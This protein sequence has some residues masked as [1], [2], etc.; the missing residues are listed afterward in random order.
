MKHASI[1]TGAALLMAVALTPAVAGETRLGTEEIFNALA[2]KTAIYAESDHV[3]YFSPAGLTPYWDGERHTEGTWSVDSNQYCSVWPP[4]PSRDCYDIYRTD[5][6]EI[7][8]VGESGKRWIA[9]MVDGN[10]MPE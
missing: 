3:Q 10:Q 6:G 1:L 5:A 8:W 7:I 4:P 9:S 2:G